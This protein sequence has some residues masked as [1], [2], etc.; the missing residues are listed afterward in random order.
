[1][2]TYILL[3]VTAAILVI[4]SIYNEDNTLIYLCEKLKRPREE[5]TP[6]SQDYM[7]IYT[8][9]YYHYF[10]F[11]FSSYFLVF[12]RGIG[13]EFDRCIYFLVV[14]FIVVGWYTFD[15]CCISY[16]ELLFYT[17][18]VDQ[19]PN[20][21]HSLFYNV[22]NNSTRIFFYISGVAMVATLPV[23]LYYSTSLSNPIKLAFYGIFLALF[24]ITNLKAM[25]TAQYYT[26]EN[27]YYKMI[28][29]SYLFIRGRKSLYDTSKNPVEQME[30]MESMEQT[31]QKESMEQKV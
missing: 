6:T 30:S 2:N 13:T 7:Y 8:I 23:L 17:T 3:C 20:T 5:I 29:E 12:F 4:I 31:E 14:M 11:L 28:K 21:F 25:T 15:G 19:V 22:F 26:S 1:M 9:R 24:T 16:L 18:E 10:I 27:R